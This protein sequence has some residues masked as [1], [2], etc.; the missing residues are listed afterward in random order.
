M[1][2][3]TNFAVILL[4]FYAWNQISEYTASTS[5]F[6]KT[7]A[8]RSTAFI[9]PLWERGDLLSVMFYV[10]TERDFT[11]ISSPS[12]SVS[13]GELLIYR[14]NIV[15]GDVGN[16]NAFSFVVKERP[17]E[18]SSQSQQ[19]AS[20]S[21][22]QDTCLGNIDESRREKERGTDVG[23]V[24]ASNEV[25]STLHTNGSS[26]FLHVLILREKVQE[27]QEEKEE[28]RRPYASCKKGICAINSED[29]L[30]GAALHISS[31]LVKHH[32][33]PS[34]R[35][36][37]RHL[38]AD[39]AQ[40]IPGT[41]L[42]AHLVRPMSPQSILLSTHPADTALSLWKPES[43]LQVVADWTVWKTSDRIPS[44]VSRNVVAERV[45]ERQQ[46]EQL[47]ADAD[48]AQSKYKPALGWRDRPLSFDDY[49]SVP[50]H[51][52]RDDLPV[53]VHLRFASLS[54]FT[55]METIKESIITQKD[56]FGSSS[57]QQAT[58]EDAVSDIFSSTSV[59]MAII[60]CLASGLHMMFE[61]L[62][63]HS[64][65]EFWRATTSLVGLSVRSVSIELMSQIIVF[66]YLW[67]S[68]ASLLIIVPSGL[69]MLLQVWKIWRVVQ[70]QENATRMPSAPVVVPASDSAANM[71]QEITFAADKVSTQ[72]LTA[73]LLPLVAIYSLWSL[74][75]HMHAGWYSWVLATTT[76][77]TYA[78]GFV[79]MFPQIYINYKL[80]SVSHLPWKFLVYRFLSTVIDDIFAFVIKTPVM[81]RVSVFR[82]DIIFV[83]Y[84]WQRWAYK[85]DTTRSP[86]R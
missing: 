44:A 13:S 60:A 55:L 56:I 31:Q 46:Q 18:F 75:V 79:S 29:I 23:V 45:G 7:D 50:L 24:Y 77:C 16:L 71:Y 19:A 51:N 5:N 6:A 63:F 11:P 1:F 64:D 30:S 57:S 14:K 8:E 32:V 17:A 66:L 62:A 59:N 12:S 4:A 26:V 68:L 35:R 28:K 52:R 9:S 3:F 37:R 61:L 73:C 53:K 72:I 69:G 48:A 80:Q 43:T 42:R 41:S 86:E 36:L 85:V 67:D 78:F 84:L 15:Y 65:I 54:D 33:I 74:V 10:S 21:E 2:T 49:I 25:W 83:I 76:A 58:L 27:E 47:R 81:H 22:A 39:I 82:D 20:L 40:Y 38:L 34:A 70:I